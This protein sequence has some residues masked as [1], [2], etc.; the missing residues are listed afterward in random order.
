MSTYSKTTVK[1][2]EE[3][4]RELRKIEPEYVKDFRK[5]ARGFAADGVK[6]A[7]EEFMHQQAGWS[8]NAP[9]SGWQKP[10][11]WRSGGG[12]SREIVF[13]KDKARRGIKFK[14]GGPRKAARTHRTYQMFS[15]IQADAAGAIYDMAGKK[16]SNPAKNFE[17]TL[18]QY[19]DTPHRRPEP[20]RPNTGPS[21]YM[22]PGVWFYLPQIED[23][24]VG[25]VRDLEA[26]VNRKLI[27]S[28]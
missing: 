9:L 21:R 3:T 16:K 11:L 4:L 6:A 22:Y 23:R 13:N 7:K 15:I 14:L 8:S 20:G 28:K 24:I 18:E 25:L 27:R 2:L 12:G 5:K 1:G 10:A 17:D 19:V 26:R